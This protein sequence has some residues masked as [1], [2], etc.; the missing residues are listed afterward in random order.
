MTSGT[1]FSRGDVEKSRSL[2]ENCPD[3]QEK[4]YDHLDGI[5]SRTALL[6]VQ[7]P[8]DHLVAYRDDHLVAYRDDHL[9]DGEEGDEGEEEAFTGHVSTLRRSQ[10]PGPGLKVR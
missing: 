4:F 7:N 2:R 5:T 9:D 6:R 10:P 1:G 3:D 8:D